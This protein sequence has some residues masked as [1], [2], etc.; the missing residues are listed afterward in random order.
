MN[1]RS[2]ITDKMNSLLNEVFFTL[3]SGFFFFMQPIVHGRALRV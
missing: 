3:F 2:R 1:N